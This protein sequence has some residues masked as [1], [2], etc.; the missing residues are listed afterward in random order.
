MPRVTSQDLYT[1]SK[2]LRKMGFE[3]EFEQ[4]EV[5]TGKVAE[6]HIAEQ[7]PDSGSLL[8]EG[9]EV[10]L[11]FN[12]PGM[13]RYWDDWVVPLL[14]DFKHTVGFYRADKPAEVIHVPG[15]EY[16]IELRKYGFSGETKVEVLV[17]FDGSVLAA[18][19]KE[20]SGYEAAD[21]AACCAGLQGRFSPA[22]HHEQPVRVWF[23]LNFFFK[24]EEAKPI[25]PS[26][27]SS[28]QTIEP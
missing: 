23:P 4:V 14:G 27:E 21:S 16:P 24:F 7:V 2:T 26:R 20:S 28:E 11:R 3:L 17:D 13:L 8:Q 12:C 25:V 18:R 10:L 6:F 9:D 19:V 15:A 22:E 5:D 1:A